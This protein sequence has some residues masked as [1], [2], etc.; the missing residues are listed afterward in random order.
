MFTSWIVNKIGKGEEKV[1]QVRILTT[2][3]RK[4]QMDKK[5]M[6]LQ[7][8]TELILKQDLHQVSI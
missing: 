5:C 4:S 3:T 8:S 7:R 1:F 2:L 6:L